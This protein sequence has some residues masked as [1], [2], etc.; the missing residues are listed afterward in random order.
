M[1]IGVNMIELFVNDAEDR[2][3]SSHASMVVELS[4]GDLFTAWFAGSVE[5]AVDTVILSSW[6]KCGEL[7][8][9]NSEVLVNVD[10]HAAGNPRL[11]YGPDSALWLIAPV[12]Y[13][14]WCHGG[15]RLF[16]KKSFDHGHTWTDL[17]LFIE[18]PGILGKNRPYQLR[19]NPDVW[20]VPTEDEDAYVCNFIRSENNG[21]SWELF[22]ELGR[23]ENI[24]VD[25]PALVEFDN[26]NLMVLMRS[27]EGY[28][29]KSQS[30]DAGKTWSPVEATELLNNNSGIDVTRAQNGDLL[31]VHNPTALSDSGTLI[32]DQ[33]L[34]GTP[35][36]ELTVSEF[37]RDKKGA[38]EKN[39]DIVLVYPKWGPRTPLRI[40]VSQDN[41]ITWTG[42][43]ELEDQP[44]EYSYPSIMQGNSGDFHIVYTYNRT[45]I[46]YVSLEENFYNK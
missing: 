37:S 4:N 11:F 32:V 34:K 20:I 25:Q 43:Y 29:Y 35:G 19:S 7:N 44:G 6:L 9:S 39:P 15:T 46:K 31:L 16:L 13:G 23:S 8:W 28:I 30:I 18:E 3:P 17:A 12:N 22:G 14:V 45:R 2:Y 10:Q 33:S 24:R 21:E 40:S 27:W 38:R 42:V 26:G 36:F 1:F 5:S 41:G